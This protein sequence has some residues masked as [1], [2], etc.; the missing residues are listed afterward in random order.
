[1][2]KQQ[3]TDKLETL[4]TQMRRL[5]DQRNALLGAAA[6]MSTLSDAVR[7]R[8]MAWTLAEQAVVQ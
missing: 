7:L 2:T 4:E 1:M 8:E 3:M 6:C 5:M